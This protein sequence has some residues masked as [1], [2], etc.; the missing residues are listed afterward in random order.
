MRIITADVKEV[1]RIQP[2]YT[3]VP[4]FNRYRLML[5]IHRWNY[6]ISIDMF[7]TRIAAAID[8]GLCCSLGCI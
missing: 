1:L 5:K 7:D 6:I 3:H 2:D 8:C 4:L